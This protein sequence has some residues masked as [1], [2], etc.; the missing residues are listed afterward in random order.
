[1]NIEQAANLIKNDIENAITNCMVNGSNLRKTTKKPFA[2]GLEAKTSLI[3][4]STLINHLHEYVKHEFIRNGVKPST[5]F[6]PLH[7]SKPELKITGMYKRKDQDVC[8]KPPNIEAVKTPINWGPMIDSGLY[9]DYGSKLTEEIIS[10]NVRSQLSSLA[11]NADTLFERTFAETLNL[12]D[13]YPRMVLGEVYMI[14]VFEY[15]D[16]PMVRNEV[17]FKKKQTDLEKYIRFFHYL[18]GRPNVD[19]EKHK[20]ERCALVIIDFNKPNAKV[21]KN[22]SELIADGLVKD[23]FKLELAD[24]SSEGFVESLLAIHKERF[25]NASIFGQ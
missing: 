12:H 20:Y 6:P 3:R 14:P 10:V 13:S 24:V 16:E 9:C 11:K 7:H 8:V 18:S 23:N 22:T 17:A 2:D 25:R 19:E 21:Y 15:D 1:M 4:S 5:I